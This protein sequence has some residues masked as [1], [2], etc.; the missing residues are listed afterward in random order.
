MYY[1]QVVYFL[2]AFKLS[3]S[4]PSIICLVEKLMAFYTLLKRNLYIRFFEL[5]FLS[6]IVCKLYTVYVNKLVY[7]SFTI[8]LND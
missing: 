7:S 4:T 6:Q 1:A 8:L 5:V 3:Y 2:N